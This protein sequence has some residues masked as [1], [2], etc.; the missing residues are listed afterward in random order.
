MAGLTA[1]MVTL[2]SLATADG[3]LIS[4]QLSAPDDR[5]SLPL[6]ALQ[7]TASRLDLEPR[8][9]S[10]DAFVTYLGKP[11][12]RSMIVA[13][14]SKPAENLEHPESLP[15]EPS[16]DALAATDEPA[17]NAARPPA[18]RRLAYAPE[19]LLGPAARGS[20][21][22]GAQ[23]ATQPKEFLPRHRLSVDVA[24]YLF[25]SLVEAWLE[26]QRVSASDVLSQA[27]GRAD[28]LMADV[29]A[30]VRLS[31]YLR[32]VADFSSQLLAVAHEID[33]TR[34]RWQLQGRDVCLLLQPEV[35]LLRLWQRVFHVA[36]FRGRYFLGSTKPSTEGDA[37]R[38]IPSLEW[39]WAES[40]KALEDDD[41]RWVIE[42]LFEG[43]WQGD[44][45][46]DFVA[47]CPSA[48]TPPVPQAQTGRR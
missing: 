38:Q 21:A 8:A 44:A 2:M 29:P 3:F 22:S 20:T 45:Q 16:M 47:L 1:V 31:A 23:V 11:Y 32:A 7:E 25:H 40:K 13:L 10:A 37:V 5:P 4:R 28:V 14:D 46:L 30:E 12:G 9:A 48:G 15:S 41:K 36:Q 19:V 34:R 6:T 35:P 18:W 39:R 26:E 27:R 24:E 42:S 33:R 17:V 43:R